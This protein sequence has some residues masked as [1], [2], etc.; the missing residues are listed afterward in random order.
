MFSCCA[1][2]QVR[3]IRLSVHE[4]ISLSVSA[5][6]VQD[7]S[8]SANQFIRLYVYQFF[9]YQVITLSGYQL[10]LSLCQFTSSS[11]HQPLYQV[12]VIIYQV[13]RLL[14]YQC[15]SLSVC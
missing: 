12:Q 10:Q 2:C 9:I 6:Q 11:A 1:G 15:M 3:V 13:V 7:V 14:G 5:C 4:F 8:L